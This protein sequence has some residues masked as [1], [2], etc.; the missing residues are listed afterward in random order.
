[1]DSFTPQ[2]PYA[3]ER[4]PV[5]I[6]QEAGQTLAG[7]DVLEYRKSPALAAIRTPDYLACSLVTIPNT[8]SRILNIDGR[9]ILKEILKNR[10]GWYGSG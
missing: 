4:S 2:S 7:L 1:V 9:I 8:L 3:R 6:A 10:V 5:L